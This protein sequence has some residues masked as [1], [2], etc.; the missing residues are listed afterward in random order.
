[1]VLPL[2]RRQGDVEGS[3]APRRLTTLMTSKAFKAAQQTFLYSTHFLASPVGSDG[4]RISAL[5][6]A[7][8][9]VFGIP[10]FFLARL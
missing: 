3:Q 1:M 10:V 7:D 9:I 6:G 2:M 8:I 4:K 5:Q